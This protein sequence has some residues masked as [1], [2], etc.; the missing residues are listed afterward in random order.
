M[1]RTLKLAAAPD[2]VALA[3]VDEAAAEFGVDPQRILSPSRAMRICL[4][5]HMAF[6]VADRLT[7]LRHHGIGNALGRDRSTVA[8]AIERIRRRAVVDAECAATLRR[9]ESAVRHRLT[10]PQM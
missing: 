9:I 6:F 10:L 5:R 8:Y 4:A 7:E 3:A 1:E 2:Q